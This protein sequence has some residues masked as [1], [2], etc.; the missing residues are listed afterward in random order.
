MKQPPQTRILAKRCVSG[1]HE[2]TYENTIVGSKGEL[3]CRACWFGHINA[4]KRR[5]RAA[6]RCE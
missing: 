2:M 5:K 6:L 3:R 1:Q 4:W